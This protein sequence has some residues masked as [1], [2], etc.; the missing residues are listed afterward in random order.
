MINIELEYSC[1]YSNELA[2]K[3]I[4]NYRVG[5]SFLYEYIS[6]EKTFNIA[7]ATD[8][9]INQQINVPRRSM[10]GLRL[11]FRNDKAGEVDSESF[12]FPSLLSVKITING[13]PN[14]LYSKG[15]D[16]GGFWEAINKRFN[17]NVSQERFL[18]RF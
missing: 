14:R 4:S 18:C 13:M 16:Q 15:M 17:N 9:I 12:L 10:N 1:V 5:K 8:E 6:L 7:L 11:L 2:N 3:A